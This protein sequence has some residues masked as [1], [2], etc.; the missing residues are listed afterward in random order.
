MAWRCLRAVRSSDET[1]SKQYGGRTWLR[2]CVSFIPC[3]P[4]K[5]SS[6]PGTHMEPA[7]WF[8]VHAAAVGSWGRDVETGRAITPQRHASQRGRETFGA[9]AHLHRTPACIIQGYNVR[10][11]IIG[12]HERD[13]AGAL[14]AAFSVATKNCQRQ[15]ALACSGRGLQRAEDQWVKAPAKSLHPSA[16]QRRVARKRR[17]NFRT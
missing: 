2:A 6:A 5:R 7:G 14:S 4:N 1:V 10:S 8:A 3:A 11:G 17:G 16:V 15:V 12:G 13:P 9:P